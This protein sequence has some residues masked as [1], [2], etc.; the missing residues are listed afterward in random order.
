MANPNITDSIEKAKAWIEQLDKEGVNALN[1]ADGI[2]HNA[3]AFVH[4][5]KIKEQIMTHESKIFTDFSKKMLEARKELDKSDL[6]FRTNDEANYE[7]TLKLW[8][9]QEMLAFW[10]SINKKIET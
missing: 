4:D 5:P 1:M 7:L 8:K 3:K 9:T 6:I 10:D 2:L